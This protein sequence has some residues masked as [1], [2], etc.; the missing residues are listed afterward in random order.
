MNTALRYRELSVKT[1]EPITIWK[2]FIGK[3]DKYWRYARN[4]YLLRV[5]IAT[6]PEYVM[7]SLDMISHCPL[8]IFV[9]QV[10]LLPL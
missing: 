8:K 1:E 4:G 6:H 5:Y 3:S 9:K 10:L 2:T 7:I